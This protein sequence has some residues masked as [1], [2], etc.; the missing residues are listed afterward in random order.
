MKPSA[1]TT[2]TADVKD[3]KVKF[4]PP[5]TA[6][7][8]AS[9]HPPSQSRGGGLDQLGRGGANDGGRLKIYKGRSTTS[10]RSARSI[11]SISQLLDIFEFVNVSDDTS[12]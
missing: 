6:S 10:I 3:V 5:S 2:P 9:H 11:R 12:L 4:E 7:H 1:T 8:P